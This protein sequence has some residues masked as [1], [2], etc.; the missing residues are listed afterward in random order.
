MSG[1]SVRQALSSL[2]VWGG[3][4]F[5]WLL[6][7]IFVAG[8][9]SVFAGTVTEW[10]T[11]APVKAER[12]LTP[13][14]S[15][16][17]LD[18]AIARMDQTGPIAPEFNFYL[19]IGYAGWKAKGGEWKEVYYD[20]ATG[21]P[22]SDG[23]ATGRTTA[24]GGHFVALHFSLHAGMAGILL[25]G[26][27]TLMMLVAL[28]SGVIIHKRIFKDFFTLRLGKGQRSWLDGHNVASVLTL[29]FQLM[30]AYTGLTIFFTVWMPASIW[31]HY[32]MPGGLE[33]ELEGK[34]PFVSA[35][36][37]ENQPPGEPAGAAVPLAAVMPLAREAVSQSGLAVEQ[38]VLTPDA[39][40]KLRLWIIMHGD[41]DHATLLPAPETVFQGVGSPVRLRREDRTPGTATKT[42]DVMYS[43]HAAHFGGAAA[44]WL[45]FLSG[46]AGC[47]MIATGLVLFTV[48]RKQRSGHEFG[49]ATSRVYRVIE[50]LNV[51]TIAG[52][53]LASAAYFW[54][55]RLLP[56]TMANRAN[57]EV[58]CFL[59]VW[60]LTLIHALLRPPRR[61]WPEQFGLAAI[62]CLGLPLL[63]LATV[64]DWFGA[65][66]RRGEWGNFGLETVAFAIGLCFAF[67][68]GRTGRMR[69]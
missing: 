19:P 5:G 39:A 45:W 46:I 36:Q 23:P 50:A 49:V 68:A 48:K 43:L 4:V 69:A 60:A 66:A 67:L 55:N 21:K 18:H 3:L 29:P 54:G 42:A 51:A 40:G 30:I 11:G 7:V 57:A 52:T 37:S 26:F 24:G 22:R 8:T 12:A 56:L 64:G 17:A 59:L 15:L 53:M 44:Q 27:V 38:I 2:H 32:G 35:S 58:I 10:M 61:A 20:L 9:I 13:E 34:S 16:R 14:E 1:G 25:V 65:Y 47:A 33:A 28:V 41:H 31:Y 6:M 62:L 63:N